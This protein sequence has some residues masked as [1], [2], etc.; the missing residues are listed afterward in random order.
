MTLLFSTRL[1]PPAELPDLDL[2]GVTAGKDMVELSP[3]LWVSRRLLGP[4]ADQLDIR[5]RPA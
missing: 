4:Y 5:N 3:R 2:E 1:T